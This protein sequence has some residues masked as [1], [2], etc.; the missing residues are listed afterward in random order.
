MRFDTLPD[1][2]AS[3]GSRSFGGF[4]AAGIGGSPS[5]NASL[6]P[7]TS[8]NFDPAWEWYFADAG[9]LTLTGFYKSVNDYIN[10]EPTLLDAEGFHV[11]RNTLIN[12]DEN[13]TLRG[14][15]VSYQQFYDFL[16]GALSGL[17][18]Q[19]NY[20]FIDA[21]GV[22]PVIDPALPAED[23]IPVARFEND[24]GIFPRVSKHN[25]NLVGL[26]EKGDIQARLAYNWRSSFQLTPRDVIFPF[27]SIYQPATG[28]LDASLFYSVTDNW[29]LGIQGVNL[30]DDITATEQTINEDGLRAPRN[31]FR[32]DRRI[33][34]IVR[35]SY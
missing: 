5:G 19:F 30:L 26:Y 3:D 33:S 20:T 10:F 14:F 2:V 16:P 1:I 28:Q 11:A 18:M 15:E 34:L 27:A 25:V 12:A 7:Q 23:D 17:G 29:K 6:L 13:A 4:T 9:S 35:A 32:N 24:R 8:W 22:E 31:Y 21:D